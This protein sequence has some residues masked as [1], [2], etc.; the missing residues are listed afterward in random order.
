MRQARPEPRLAVVTHSSFLSSCS[1]RW[2]A[3]ATSASR[4]SCTAGAPRRT[5]PRLL[6]PSVEGFRLNATP[7]TLCTAIISAWVAWLCLHF[8]RA[9]DSLVQQLLLLVA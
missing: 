2:A 8:L 3:G 5:G 9:A 6:V 4:A 1:P 7:C